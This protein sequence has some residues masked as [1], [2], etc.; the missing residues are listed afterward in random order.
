MKTK[1]NPFS[2]EQLSDLL[3]E[4]ADLYNRTSFIESDPVSI[5]H[6][7]SSKGDIEIAGFLT[8][9]IAWGQ[10]ITL[11][12]NANWLLD[13]MDDSPAEF[14]S[15]FL[16]SDLAPFTS[17]V[18]RTFNGDDCLFF[19]RA[20]QRIISEYGSLENA[21]DP[22]NGNIK[23]GIILFRNRFLGND[24][25]QRS[26]KH[27]SDPAANSAAKRVNMF[28][29]WMIRKDQRN[30][31]FGIW[32]VFKMSELMCPLDV[33]S[34]GVARKLGLLQRKQDDWKAVEELTE[35]LRK[36]DSEDPVKYDYALFGLGV[37]EGFRKEL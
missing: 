7:F 32:N 17:F 15:S 8:A 31:D 3:N 12:R 23:S 4:K 16:E 27:I 10:R 13:R 26:A 25:P 21:F 14:I 29:R 37:F 11:I 1:I 30:V 22:G 2:F 20:L 9:T 24:F 19:L 6:R 28:L 34:G 33:H 5:P 36:F 18:H 35:N